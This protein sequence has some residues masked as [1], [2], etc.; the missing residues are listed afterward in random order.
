MRK[1]EGNRCRILRM[2]LGL[3]VISFRCLAQETQT[4]AAD[5]R[6]HDQSATEHTA[7]N[8]EPGAPVIKSKD[9]YEATGYFH[10]FTRIP[11][12]VAHDQK[13]IWTS[14]FHTQKANIKWWVIV[15]GA[16]GVLI[17]TDK[18]T[19]KQFPNSSTQISVSNW[20]SRFGS[21]YS[22]IPISTA[23][24]LLGTHAH[25]ERIRETGLIGFETLIDANLTVQAL[26]LVADRARPLSTN[27]TGRFEDY[28]GARW[29]S[30]FPS[31]HAINSWAM[32]SVIAHEYRHSKLIPIIAYGLAA[33]VSFARVGARQHFPG[34]VVVGSALGWFIGDY[35][36]G[37]RH[38]E[39]L[40]QTPVP[41]R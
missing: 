27:G 25:Q 19:V 3:A 13:A 41:V 39:A 1:G 24:Y 38:N 6:P 4:P 36:Y 12:Y 40:D 21:S 20:G 26:K 8:V 31:G 16:A 34:D 32:A 5:Q 9:I 29:N 2:A 10:P 14:P 17:A 15:G 22:V 30:S 35:V 28:P 7:L 37:K 11:R 23:F 18:H 33:T